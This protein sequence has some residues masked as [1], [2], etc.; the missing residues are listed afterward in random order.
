VQWAKKE[1]ALSEAQQNIAKC[2]AKCYSVN[3]VNGQL[4]ELRAGE[5]GY[6]RLGQAWP[7]HECKDRKITM[8]E[9]ADVL[10]VENGVTKNQREAMECGS[11]WGWE[12]PGANPDIYD[13]QGIIIKAK[14]KE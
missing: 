12:V 3:L 6:Y 2:P 14:L 5:K 13:E 11:M 1:P 8:D 7:Q 10:N 9:F 4:I